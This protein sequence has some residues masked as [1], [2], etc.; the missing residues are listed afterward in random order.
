MLPPIQ[1]PP[2]MSRLTVALLISCGLTFAAQAQTAAPAAAATPSAAISTVAPAINLPGLSG[3]TTPTPAGQVVDQTL[4]N[5]AASADANSDP[6]VVETPGGRAVQNASQFQAFVKRATGQSLPIF[7]S[8]LFAS[9]QTYQPVANIA[10]PANYTLGP[11]D[12]IQ[13]QVWGAVDVNT[14][15][16]VDKRG[17]LTVPRVGPLSVAGLKV[18]QLD[19][20]L[21]EHV[22]QVFRNV[23]VSATVA[24]LHNIQI[25]VVGQARQPGTYTLSSLSTLVNALFAS[26][27]ANAFGS[28]RN[29][30]LRRDNTTVTRLDL[31]DFIMK[32][33]R[34]G[35]VTLQAGDVIVFPP[36]GPQ[37]AMV[38]ALDQAAI[39]ELKGHTSLG[40]LLKGMGG[41]PILSNVRGATLERV[42]RDQNPPRQVSDITLNAIGLSTA[43]ADGDIITL[44]PISLGLSNEVTLKGP[45]AGSAKV[46]WFQGMRISDLIPST[47]S[48]IGADY[49]ERKFGT[50]TKNDTVSSAANEIKSRFDAINWD[51]AVVERLDK[52]ILKNQLLP[53]NLRQAVL[54]HQQQSNLLLQPGDVVTVFTQQDIQLPEDKQFRLIKI[55][56]EVMAPGV[57]NAKPGET[58]PQLLRRI[59]GLTP[60]AYLFG[61]RFYRE[62]VRESQQKNLDKLV[63]QLQATLAEQSNQLGGGA[64]TEKTAA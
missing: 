41:V 60:Q 61:T 46:P 23:E 31:Y 1:I 50:A 30:E 33:E 52:S 51:Y 55:E 4:G 54:E 42:V 13:L 43:L 5:T 48:L 17:V 10:P 7:G 49:F 45:G 26:G 39:Y 56:G 29:I 25:Y 62:S 35:D 3:A 27:G 53:F 20:A 8:A 38:G 14:V 9:P 22:H 63:S 24:R 12:Q 2:F 64:S 32:G 19:K 15:L 11:G 21:S 16:T 6:S 34:S 57:Y 44:K 58:L 40:D 28:M 37:V 59:G 47:E 18:G 36:V